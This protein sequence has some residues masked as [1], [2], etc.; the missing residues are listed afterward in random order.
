MKLVKFFGL[1]AILLMVY[2]CGGGEGGGKDE[3]SKFDAIDH[4]VGQPDEGQADKV[5][6]DKGQVTLDEGQPDQGI[7]DQGQPDQGTL[8]QGQPDLGQ[9]D[10]V[11]DQGGLQ[12]DKGQADEGQGL[13]DV[14]G[15]DTP[16]ADVPSGQGTC[17]DIV[18]CIQD[19]QCA[20]QTCYQ[21]CMAEGTA[22]AQEQF[23]EL[24]Q[25]EV[26]QC[27]QYTQ[28][29]PMQAVYCLYT[30]CKAQN[31]PCTKT[32]N[33]GCMAVLQCVQGCGQ[34]PTCAGDCIYKGTYDA[35]TALFGILACVEE[36]CPN[37]SQQCIMLNCMQQVLACQ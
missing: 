34:D 28:Q 6:G 21:Q 29:Q 23:A 19:K 5:E 22:T 24:A 1:A 12:T 2:A 15:V 16:Q 33:L 8:D 11:E 20:D 25:C 30:K 10:K 7:L 17:V 35:Q 14:V 26:Q 37:P 36:K 3:T 18:M 32:G 27:G 31:E 13:P 9:V 4:G